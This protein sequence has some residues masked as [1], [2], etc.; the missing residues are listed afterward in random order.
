MSSSAILGNVV[1]ENCNGTL[2][3]IKRIGDVTLSQEFV[4]L[5][6]NNRRD[7]DS[8]SETMVD[9]NSGAMTSGNVELVDIVDE[10]SVPKPNVNPSY[11]DSSMENTSST[12]LLKKEC[13]WESEL[14]IFINLAKDDVAESGVAGNSEIY[15]SKLM[16]KDRT[17]ALGMINDAFLRYINDEYIIVNILHTI[18]HFDYE[19]VYPEAQTMALIAISNKNV[20]VQ[21]FA[22]KCYENWQSKEAIHILESTQYTRDWLSEYANDVIDDL[23]ELS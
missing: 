1:N 16:E 4:E 7:L 22:I 6:L 15:F 3:P 23:K 17:F 5:Y 13:P 2:S 21:E 20:C 11:M 14:H 8:D 9:T 19:D 12:S 10:G 18:S